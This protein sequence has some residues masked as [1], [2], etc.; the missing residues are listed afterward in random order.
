MRLSA[1]LSV[2]DLPPAELQAGVLDGEL[3]RVGGAYCTIDTV[4]GPFHRAASI[5]AEV[6]PW[7]IAERFTAAWVFGVVR[8]QPRQLQLCV[9]SDD[10][11]R[12]FS[13]ARLAFREVILAREDTVTIAGLRVTSPLRTAIDFARVDE[14]FSPQTSAIVRGL[15]TLGGGFSLSDCVA[16]MARKR[17]LPFKRK[18]IAR[19][20]MSLR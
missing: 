9:D 18:A 3:V 13:S 4:V 20:T 16:D 19:L 1:V 7:A 12:P 6:A 5:V 17:N 8:E 11:V 15:S 10:N 2:S 14:N